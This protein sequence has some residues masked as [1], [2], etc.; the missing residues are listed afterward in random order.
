M[1]HILSSVYGRK[2]VDSGRQVNGHAYNLFLSLFPFPV[3]Q[4]E[5]G[6]QNG[7]PARDP[8]PHPEGVRVA[9]PAS[10]EG[11]GGRDEDD[12]EAAAA[13]EAAERLRSHEAGNAVSV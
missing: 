2:S 6:G 3:E 12:R 7:E 5:P 11:V 10:E 13:T 9:D 4:D 8:G 1:H